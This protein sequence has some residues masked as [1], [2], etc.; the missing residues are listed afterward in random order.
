MAMEMVV[1]SN[2]ELAEERIIRKARLARIVED[3]LNSA[4]V[5]SSGESTIR[6]KH[7]GVSPLDFTPFR[8]NVDCCGT[9]LLNYPTYV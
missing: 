5:I 1:V 3:S 9:P 7:N 2:P 8:A 4:T 6:C